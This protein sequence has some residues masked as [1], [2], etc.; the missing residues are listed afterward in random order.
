MS[1]HVVYTNGSNAGYQQPSCEN[2]F[3]ASATEIADLGRERFDHDTA[4]FGDRDDVARLAGPVILRQ[5]RA[6]PGM[7]NKV[8]EWSL[9]QYDTGE[10]NEREELKGELH[11]G[12][13]HRQNR[14][15]RGELAGPPPPQIHMAPRSGRGGRGMAHGAS[16]MRGGMMGAG[17]RGGF[18]MDGG[19][20]APEDL[21]AARRTDP[22]A[23]PLAKGY[24]K[25]LSAD[26]FWSEPIVRE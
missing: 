16:S 4:A 6:P 2:P 12:Q 23:P 15:A 17:F 1:H 21:V 3:Y 13:L 20:L 8:F 9:L 26:M 7:E 24:P 18:A 22:N 11:G 14:V 19:T 25:E 5:G 10:Q